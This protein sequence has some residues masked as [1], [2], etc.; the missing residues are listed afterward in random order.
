M[1]RSFKSSGIILRKVDF[2]D[3]DRIYTILTPERKLSAIARGIRR[4]QAKLASHMEM[5]SEI[6]LMFVGGKRMDVITSA[7]SM[8]SWSI[9]EDYE[10]M[11]RGFLFLEMIDKMTDTE[12]VEELYSLL[13][14]SL[15]HLESLQPELCELY[16][17]LNLL[18]ILGHTPDVLS[19]NTHESYGLDVEQGAIVSASSPNSLS[20]SRDEIK[21]WRLLLSRPLESVASIKGVGDAAESSMVVCDRFIVSQFGLNFRSAEI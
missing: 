15:T 16:F 1:S 21:L 7:R 14:D 20:M 6:E 18:R 4:A 13:T 17:K 12:G 8:R 5:F 10:R 9:S 3:A 2:A 11:R 19:P